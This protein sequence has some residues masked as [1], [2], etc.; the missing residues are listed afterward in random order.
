MKVQDSKGKS[1]LPPPE[2]RCLETTGETRSGRLWQVTEFLQLPD[3]AR[4]VAFDRERLVVDGGIAIGKLAR[5]QHEYRFEHVMGDGDDRFFGP[6]TND[7]ALITALELTGS[8]HGGPGDLTEHSAD[9]AVARAVLP[10]RRLPA[11]SW[12]PGHTPSLIGSDQAILL[13]YREKRLYSGWYF[14]LKTPFGVEK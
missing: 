10:D 13:M 8:S 1:N 7:Q 14:S 12:L 5:Q 9:I 2:R 4:G 11:D 3:P 6:P